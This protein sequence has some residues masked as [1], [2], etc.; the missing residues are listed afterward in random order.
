MREYGQIQTSYWTDPDIQPL[1]D[2]AKILGAYLLTG[3]HSNGIGCYRLPQGYVMEDLNWSFETISKSFGELLEIGFIQQDNRTGWVFI[4]KFLHWN[5]IRNPNVATKITKEFHS[6]PKTLC[7][8]KDLIDSIKLYGKHF[9]NDFLNDLETIYQTLSKP[10]PTRSLPDP[11]PDPDPDPNP[12]P[13]PKINPPQPPPSKKS[14][15]KKRNLEKFKIIQRVFD[16]WREVMNHPNAKLDDKR[17]KALGK[18]LD[19]EYTENDLQLAIRG[20]KNTPFNM[21]DNDRGEIYD[22]LTLILRDAKHIEQFICNYHNPPKPKNSA[23][24]QTEQNLSVAQGWANESPV[25]DRN[26]KPSRASS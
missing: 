14:A 26:V 17:K 9:S 6:V 23:Q 3:T 15:K 11:Y 5:P 25:D 22:D 4:P 18:A 20:C 13:D 1:S 2:Q 19:L 8:Y 21:G 12:K 10:N 7:F 24:R 16:A